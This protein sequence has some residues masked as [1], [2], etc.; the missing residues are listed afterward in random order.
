MMCNMPIMIQIGECVINADAIE[1]IYCINDELII[2]FKSGN[3][4]RKRS[5]DATKIM[6][7][8]TDQINREAKEK[9]GKFTPGP[10][11][12][13]VP[14]PRYGN[15][16]CHSIIDGG[17]EYVAKTVTVSVL[18][19]ISAVKREERKANEHLIETAPDMYDGIGDAVETMRMIESTGAG[20]CAD[21]KWDRKC[22]FCAMSEVLRL[23]V[24]CR[25]RLEKIQKKARGEE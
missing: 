23:A 12:I 20:I 2:R 4:H 24:Q 1:I 3:E 25:D 6:R 18:R 8:I 15:R 5:L 16:E 10:W 7:E 13:L 14:K 9:K 19:G 21:C 17:G 22:S 11:H